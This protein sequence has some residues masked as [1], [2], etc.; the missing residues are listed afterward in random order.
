MN[1]VYLFM[2]DINVELKVFLENW[3][4]IYVFLIFEFLISNNLKRK[5]Y[6]LVILV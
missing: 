3:N 5:L 6:V 4:S 1:Y 2:V